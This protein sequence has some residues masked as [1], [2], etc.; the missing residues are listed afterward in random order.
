MFDSER[1]EKI[2][3]S[4]IAAMIMALATG[5]LALGEWELGWRTVDG[6]G[7]MRSTSSSFELSGTIGQ[8]DAGRSDGPNFG[9]TGGF[10]F[11][12]APGDCVLTGAI[13]LHDATAFESCAVGPEVSSPDESCRCMDFDGDGDVDLRD[14]AEFQTFFAAP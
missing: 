12:H 4:A 14:A 6:G 2:M 10:W 8:P 9:L 7:A 5:S 3:K 11:E 13:T 1:I